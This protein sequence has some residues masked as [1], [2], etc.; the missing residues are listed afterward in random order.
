[1]HSATSCVH[2]VH[3]GI[4]DCGSDFINGQLAVQLALPHS[5]LAGKVWIHHDS[6]VYHVD[7]LS[8]FEAGK[9]QVSKG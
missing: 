2:L 8:L 9:L 4:K 1:M 3:S 5:I 7:L 6:V